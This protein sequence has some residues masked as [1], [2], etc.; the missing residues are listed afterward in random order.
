MMGLRMTEPRP[1]SHQHVSS[2]FRLDEVWLDN[3]C[4]AGWL[5]K[6]TDTLATTLEGRMR[7]DYMLSKL[8]G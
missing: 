8:L 2:K 7:L 5:V 3:F 4:E 6:E 1:L